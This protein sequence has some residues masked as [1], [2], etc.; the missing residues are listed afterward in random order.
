MQNI[1][2]YH[3]MVLTIA[4]VSTTLYSCK[5]DKPDPGPTDLGF[6][7]LGEAKDYVYFKKG[8]WWVY[9]NTRTKEYDTLEVYFN[10][11]DTLEAT[12]KN[13]HFTNELFD[14]KSKS[15]TTGHIYN[16][17][18]RSAAVETIEQPDGFL[19][20]NMERYNPYEGQLEPFYYPFNY[21]NYN[22]CLSIKDTMIIKS[23]I[24][25]NV[26]IFYIKSD[27]HEPLPLKH[28]AAKYYWAK[29]NGLI[30][31]ELFKSNFYGDTSTLYHAWNLINS[32]IIQ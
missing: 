6:F 31:K 15:L 5:P 24:Y 28:N 12:S 8:T 7:G 20:P 26:A 22:Y 29:K 32:N 10:L 14:V 18:E 13:W 30:K 17:Y 11:L 27:E 9:Q 16:F 3:I 19:V 21:K 1:K 2:T 25:H 23:N 4:I